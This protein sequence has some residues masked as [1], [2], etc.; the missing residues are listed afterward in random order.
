[1]Q[2]VKVQ[3]QW[4]QWNSGDSWR[5]DIVPQLKKIGLSESD[6]KSCVY[7]ISANGL[8]AI[9]YPK[10]ESPTLYIGSGNFKARMAQHESW[11][12]EITALVHDYSFSIALCHPKVQGKSVHR[13]MEAAL[14]HQFIEMFGCIPIRNKKLENPSENYNYSPHSEFKRPLMIGRGF[15][16]HWAI[17]PMKSNRYYKAYCDRLR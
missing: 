8:F 6:L 17:R 3:W 14:I 2:T 15:R 12:G 1:M 9:D 11:L 7:V 5:E 10:K 4:I 16:Y 13:A